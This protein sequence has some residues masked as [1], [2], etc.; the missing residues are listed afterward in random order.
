M[1]STGTL[2]RTNSQRAAGLVSVDGRTYPLKSARLEAR[3]EGGVAATTFT[4]TYSNPYEEPLEVLYTLPLPADGAVT[5]Y[6]IR[7]GSRVI[8]G[9]VRRR[10]EAQE[11]YRKALL[12]GRTAALLE[13]ERADTFTQKLGCLPPGE[14]AEVEIRVTQMLAYL[15]A[16]GA[17]TARWEYRFPTVAGVRYEGVEGRVPDAEKLDVD[18]AG[19]SGTPVRLEASLL[20]M[21]GPAE[22][23]R[24]HAPGF[25]LDLHERD[26][27]VSVSLRDRMRLDR[28]LVVRWNAAKQEVGVRLV[29]G[30]GLPGDDGRYVMITLTP[31]AEVRQGMARDLTVLIDAS[32]SMSGVPI[33][34][35]KIVAEELLRSLDPED[36]FEILAF[37]V[38]VKRLVGSPRQVSAKSIREALEAVHRLEAGGGTEMARAIVEALR[39]LRPNSQ[40]QVIL[41]TDGYIGFEAEVI[42]EILQRLVPGARLHAVG[43]GSA[44]NRTLIRGAA[45]AGRGVE[46]LV[47]DDDDARLASRRLLQATVRPLL[48][49]LE[50]NGPA[51]I[52]LAPERP[53]DVLEGQ[54]L[55]LLAEVSGSGGELEIRARQAMTPVSWQHRIRV[56]AA[57]ETAGAAEE[58]SEFAGLTT[59]PLGA[60]FGR[61]AIEDVE[62]GLAAV[63]HGRGREAFENRIEELGLRHGIASRKTSLVAISEDP[64]VDPKDPR[65]RE[66]LP[67]EVPAEVSAEGAGLAQP[68]RLLALTGAPALVNEL[69]FDADESMRPG[70]RRAISCWRLG[71]FAESSIVSRRKI[72]GTPVGRLRIRGPRVLDI[73]GPVLIFEFDVP[74]TGFFLPAGGAE[75]DVGFEDGSHCMAGVIGDKS[76]SPGPHQQGL[77]VRLAVKLADRLEWD[78]TEALIRWT[79]RIELL[80]DAVA[81]LEIEVQLMLGEH[82]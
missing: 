26:G 18:R 53:Q 57:G 8:R 23:V 13:Q 59:L 61:E 74:A 43:I 3:A 67:V 48:T 16:D 14:T 60:L 11:Q 10:T 29:E 15:P 39:P 38:D 78:G 50:V 72:A 42:G 5:G 52:K 73:E 31:P 71:K 82:P 17:G 46:I 40:R 80:E 24:P 51:L 37:S 19:G 70:V 47:G 77:T 6:T 27:G 22:A 54:P 4:Q 66:R 45:R 20:V 49:D 62:L 7:L 64:T 1:A 65:R 55:I 56:P 25:E 41:I 28:D 9:E 58:G 68:V 35:A 75:L 32:G 2:P 33:S 69:S 34:R 36:R 79:G 12:E 21:D 63:R 44:P 30:K 76:S 81:E